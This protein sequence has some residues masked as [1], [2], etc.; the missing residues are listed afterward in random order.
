MSPPFQQE[1]QMKQR[2]LWRVFAVWFLFV[3]FCSLVFA[4]VRL[5]E[6]FGTD[7]VLQ[8]DMKVPVWGWA[9]AGEKVTVSFDG[10][11]VF[12]T[13][14]A[15]GKWKVELSPLKANATPS[16]L[17]VKGTNELKLE[18]VLV[19]EVW[20][21]S[22]QSNMEWTMNRSAEYKDELPKT[23][24]A[25]IRLFHVAKAWDNSPKDSLSATWKQCNTE[26]IPNFS[27]VGYYF[28][29]KISADLDVPVGLIDSSWGDLVSGRSE[30]G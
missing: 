2:N 27:A 3:G 1:F 7:M 23:N 11:I 12:A 17:T 19:G 20:L 21:C 16:V 15:A 8:R 29:Q 13:A 5:P 28:G 26:N 9:D 25:K 10:Q 24:N 4:D 6:I 14:D 30:Y 18:N 22:G